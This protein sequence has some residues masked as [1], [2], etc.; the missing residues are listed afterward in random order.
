[1]QRRRSH[2]AAALS[3]GNKN[4]RSLVAQLRTIRKELVDEK[5]KS[6][7]RLSLLKELLR[8]ETISE[9]LMQAIVRYVEGDGDFA[10]QPFVVHPETKQITPGW[11]WTNY[12]YSRLTTNLPKAGALGKL[13]R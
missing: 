2:K 5:A 6:D 8:A 11:L 7:L 4:E 12:I 13:I 10:K 1:M 3:Y 9:Q